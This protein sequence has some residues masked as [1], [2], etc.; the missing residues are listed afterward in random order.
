MQNL[1]I[2][3]HLMIVLAMIGAILLQR[4]VSGG[5]GLGGN[6]DFL[7]SRP[8]GNFLTRTT[9]YLAVA[10]FALTVALTISGREVPN[11]DNLSDELDTLNLEGLEIPDLPSEEGVTLDLPD[12]PS[13]EG[14]TLDLPDLP[15]E[16]ALTPDLPQAPTLETGAG[17]ESQNAPQ[18]GSPTSGQ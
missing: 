13:E 11:F 14:V 6:D 1:L 8:R 18:E 17:G 5:L 7:R 9:T 16:E 10:F 12:L 3:L 2:T 15:S 4:P